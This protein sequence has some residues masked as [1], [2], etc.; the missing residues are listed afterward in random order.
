MRRR[1]PLSLSRGLTLG[2]TAAGVTALLLV[3]G[4]SAPAFATEI[5]PAHDRSFVTA[6]TTLEVTGT[7][8]VA[9]GRSAFSEFDTGTALPDKVKLRTDS[10]QMITITGALTEGIISGSEFSG[11]LAVPADV[12]PSLN[13]AV[14]AALSEPGAAASALREAVDITDEILVASS[15][16]AAPLSV[17]SASITAPVVA[18]VIAPKTHTIDVMVFATPEDGYPVSNAGVDSA[19]QT[20]GTFWKSQSA[21][22]VAGIVKPGAVKRTV[23]P[24]AIACDVDLA[25]D[26]AL[27]DFGD[28]SG[29]RYFTTSDARHLMV[30]VPT[31]CSAGSGWGTIGALNQGGLIWT[32]HES[33]V[34][35]STLAHEFGH[36]LG[37][38]HSNSHSCPGQLVEGTL[39]ADGTFSDG[40]HDNEYGDAYD[41]MAASY[42]FGGVTNAQIPALN[43]THK[44]ALGALSSTDLPTIKRTA[45][46]GSQSRT[47]ALNPI[48]ATS[49]LRGLRVVDPRTNEQYFVEY[50]SGTGMDAGALYTGNY[51]EELAPGVRVLRSRGA[52]ELTGSTSAVLTLPNPADPD[53]RH[54]AMKT[55][56][57]LKIPSGN[58]TVKVGALGASAAVTITLGSGPAT[59]AVDR[60]SGDDRYSTA[61]AIS[62]A[63]Y[64]ATAPI[65]YLATG[66]NYPD[67]L[68]AAP[69]AAVQGGPLLLTYPTGLPDSV[70]DEI[71]RL[72]PAKIVVVGGT[73]AVSPSVVSALTSL[74][75]TV[76]RVA[77][78]DRY[79]TGRKIVANAFPG[80]VASA[81][82]ATGQN[83][84]D[85]L[86][87]SAAA[88]SFGIPVV[89]VDG[90]VGSVN[91]DTTRMLRSMKVKSLTVVGGPQAVSTGISSAL[92]AVAPVKRISG[93]DRFDTSQKVVNSAFTSVGHAYFAT[94]Y[95]FPDALAGAALAG[96]LKSPLY[97]V[98]PG[99]VP[100]AIRSDLT[101]YKTTAVTLLGGPA[102]LSADVAS[103]RGC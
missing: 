49:G 87:A 20:I 36:N 52:T 26:R 91:P 44:S 37:L 11:T 40:C 7:V 19:L 97:V 79:D 2:G 14:E 100:S 5:E 39:R 84:P 63:G 17:V 69:A 55:G 22:Q 89:L 10:G 102:A 30:I 67:A 95:Q 86:S 59:P 8:V 103:L 58:L 46:L 28:P 1:S 4:L 71:K 81:Y 61:V 51:Y 68:S 72:K 64:P 75:P 101:A 48:S 31:S 43:V 73:A 54:F 94:G 12:A 60:I 83:Y 45:T 3:G 65:V 62:R 53:Y 82:I 76:S 24:R 99:C 56:E 90:A 66:E 15:E 34:G 93:A 74:A 96:S 85:A 27:R 33:L 18:A 77:G 23:V 88:G 21:N 16:I 29:D 13:V 57:S 6:S 41:V 25:W 47:F 98:Q 50:R 70:R 78:A 92:T 9:S 38:G 80:T 32:S 42:S 35:T